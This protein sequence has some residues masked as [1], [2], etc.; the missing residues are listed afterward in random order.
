MEK[1]NLSIS[2]YIEIISDKIEKLRTPLQ[3]EHVM[4]KSLDDLLTQ[5][6]VFLHNWKCA[7]DVIMD[8]EGI[9]LSTEDI[10]H[11]EDYTEMIPSARPSWL[12]KRLEDAKTALLKHKNDNILFAAYDIEY[13]SG[14][15]FVLFERDGVLYEVN[16]SHCSCYGLEGQWEEEET[17]LDALVYRLIN[18]TFGTNAYNEDYF[19][20]D[21]CKFL[22]ISAVDIRKETE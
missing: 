12:N 17:T 4:R 14:E 10:K 8:F 22:G 2:D 5:P 13:Y 9:E 11:I 1:S 16:G 6:P 21:L 3:S 20:N 7:F 15:A 19:R 18:G